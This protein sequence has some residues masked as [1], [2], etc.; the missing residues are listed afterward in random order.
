GGNDPALRR[1]TLGRP[2]PGSEPRAEGGRSCV[3]GLAQDLP[4]ERPGVALRHAGRG[5][6]NQGSWPSTWV[7]GRPSVR[8]ADLGPRTSLRRLWPIHPLRGRLAPMPHAMGLPD[9]GL[10]A[11]DLPGLEPSEGVGGCVPTPRAQYWPA[12]KFC[13]TPL[14]ARNAPTHVS[15]RNIHRVAAPPHPGGGGRTASARPALNLEQVS[16]QSLP[17]RFEPAAAWPSSDG[18]VLAWAAGAKALARIG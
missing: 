4:E 15:D 8:S 17:P 13:D 10:A 11:P 5:L 9:R 12:Y 3:G 7:P 6:R 18:A 14:T 1:I 16:Q 2:P